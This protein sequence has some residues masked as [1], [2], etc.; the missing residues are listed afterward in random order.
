[1]AAKVIQ[2]ALA[3]NDT[4]SKGLVGVAKQ[5]R[6]QGAEISKGM[7]Q[8]ARQ[9]DAF[10]RSIVNA[11]DTSITKLG[12]LAAAAGKTAVKFSFQTG[13]DFESQM[14][15]VQSI[16]IPDI[17]ADDARE[18]FQAL[19]DKAREV[20]RVS[21]YTAT[22]AAQGLEYM[23][24]A[25][26]N[27]KGMLDGLP[28]IVNL[29]AASGAE[30]AEVS[31]I[32]TDTMTA[33]HMDPSEAKRFADV[34][35]QT[36]RSA[37][38]DVLKM[39]ETFKYVGSTIGG[40]KYEIEDTAFAIGLMANNGVK[41]SQAGTAL[42]GM[43]TNIG[44]N[45]N[46][47]LDLIEGLGVQFYKAD[48]SARALVDVMKELRQATA[49]FTMEE[50]N[51]FAYAVAGKN[52]QD[53]LKAILDST[54]EKYNE[55]ADAIANSKGAAQA[56]ADV[57]MN[58]LNGRMGQLKGILAE[59][60]IE[61]YGAFG[62][63]A[64]NLVQTLNDK[65][66]VLVENGII[67]QWAE[68]LGDALNKAAKMGGKAFD[69]IQ[70]HADTLKI[71]LGGL[72]GAVGGIW[73][74]DKVNGFLTSFKKVKE[75]ATNTLELFSTL[76]SVN[77]FT[78]LSSVF[79]KLSHPIKTVG[80]VLQNNVLT[81]PERIAGS[82]SSFPVKISSGFSR[83]FSNINTLIGGA[84]S[85]IHALFDKGFSFIF[86]F[87][88]KIVNGFKSIPSLFKSAFSNINTLVGGA[89]SNIHALFD[90]GF[91]FIFSLPGKI[92]GVF[93]G[94]PGKIV[95]LVKGIPA[96]I[97]GL[98]TSPAA[99]GA[100]LV[101]GLIAVGVA[102]YKNWDTIKAKAQE[103]ASQFKT[104]FAPAI[105][106]VKSLFSTIAAVFTTSV[107][108]AFK[109]IWEKAKETGGSL[110]EKLAPAGESILGLF[111]KLAELFVNNVVPVIASVISVVAQFAASFLQVA[112]P[113]IAAVIEKIV[114][115]AAAFIGAAIPAI[116]GVIEIAGNLA[117]KF[118]DFVSPAVSALK[119]IFMRLADYLIERIPPVFE[120]VKEFAQK[121]SDFFSSVFAPAIDA[122]KNAFQRV[123]ETVEKV[124]DKIKDFLGMNTSKTVSVNYQTTG[125][126]IGRNANGTKSWRGGLTWINER[127]AEIISLPGGN[128]VVPMPLVQTVDNLRNNKIVSPISRSISQTY[129]NALYEGKKT[130]VNLPQGTQIFSH[131]QSKRIIEKSIGYNANGT[132]GS[133]WETVRRLRENFQQ[134]ETSGLVSL[135]LPEI[136]A[137][138]L[139]HYNAVGKYRSTAQAASREIPS[140]AESVRDYIR[141]YQKKTARQKTTNNETRA[142]VNITIQIYGRANESDKEFAERIAKAVKNYV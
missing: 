21:K 46:G 103:L 121:V 13:M 39:G 78:G 41:A 15:K 129:Y 96:A 138:P 66:T 82:F 116:A 111:G 10:K 75:N 51:Q 100:A 128:T 69:W 2:I 9:A 122:V 81:I 34:L 135:V 130:L 124:I 137:Y 71:V 36:S 118:L 8:A 7:M 25:G 127:G 142:P 24:M 86:S 3:L 53:G 92:G 106:A 64:K 40:N 125:S 1:M 109:N 79:D 19:I 123:K 31:E 139:F 70:K 61:F 105:E 114:P 57:Q 16:A 56:M 26:W 93:A 20:G 48:G 29:A 47:A 67:K 65:I 38:T 107:I 112:V 83:A 28:H 52:A 131:L 108:P 30:L 44:I 91:S 115:F 32:V 72:A 73:I 50:K 117:R 134:Y 136:P 110:M 5:A 60:G 55:L 22:E 132:G 89:F 88:G 27:V 119:D 87:P 23:G 49:D 54:E 62:E 80:D 113:A 43:L 76:S 141:E 84:F 90:K 120:K 85:N 99:W 102:I 97:G 42:R 45:K 11:V 18:N 17:N 68:S 14:A 59:V 126:A 37:S 101:V 98:L 33:L 35:A 104:N 58:T 133:I 140:V 94:L 63:K 95:G 6:E 77:G 12:K 4:F 74:G